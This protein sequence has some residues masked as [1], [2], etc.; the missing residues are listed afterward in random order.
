MTTIAAT[1]L[2]KR[3][4]D[5]VAV[6]RLSLRVP[7]GEIYALLGLNGA[8]KTTTIRMLLGMVRPTSGTVSL[9]GT[10]V[11]PAARAVWSRVGYLVETPAAYPELTVAENLAVAARLRGLGDAPVGEVIAR[12][13]LEPYAT[14]RAR[15]LS[16]GNAQRLGLAKALLHRP[17][18][19]VLDEPA[20]GLDPAG[21]A[22]IRALLHDLAREGVTV[23]LSSHILT[24]VARL[25]GR[26]GVLDR[27]RLVWE[28]AT[29]DLVARARP[30]LRV[31][32][33]D[34]VAGAAALHAA[35][36]RAEDT[37]E[38]GFVLSEDTA[39]RRP[40]DVAALLAAA[41]CPPT[42]LAVE[43]DDLETCFLRLVGT[44]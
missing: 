13:G 33:R 27:G 40:D 3:Y 38:P 12:L 1:E 37:G 26:I 4:R 35:G 30:R 31:A 16:L 2:T 36:Y 32:V 25:A 21:V 23:L 11:R 8:G 6:D 24:E 19:L 18:L 7:P 10:P 9:L 15:T 22:E 14:R 39:I 20:N 44:P 28:G 43:Q 29:S 41:G 34:R 17:E 42:R 5:V